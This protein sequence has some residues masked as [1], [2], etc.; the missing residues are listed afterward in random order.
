MFSAIQK[1]ENPEIRKS[2]NPKIH[3]K[4]FVLLF[5]LLASLASAQLKQ[6]K[7]VSAFNDSSN[8][9]FRSQNDRVSV[10]SKNKRLASYLNRLSF[11]VFNRITNEFLSSVPE[12]FEVEI[13]IHRNVDDIASFLKCDPVENK[14]K[15][16]QKD[17]T[18]MSYQLDNKNLFRPELLYDD[19]PYMITLAYLNAADPDGKIPSVLKIGLA[20]SM[21]RSATNIIKNSLNQ[22]ESFWI[23]QDEFFDFKPYE[24]DEVIYLNKVSGT[25]AAWAL[26]LKNN[27]SK[28]TLKNA[29]SEI[30]N[31]KEF[32]VTL[33]EAFELGKYDI[34]PR[35]EEKI[36]NW[37]LNNFYSENKSA[38]QTTIDFKPV[39]TK[40]LPA[41]AVIILVFA[42]LAWIK[43]SIL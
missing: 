36:K 7:N 5:L 17:S 19:I 30:I 21:E 33:G 35:L 14:L 31:G 13:Y 27:C 18:L 3:M 4:H 15:R 11:D 8:T 26:Y 16:W 24:L 29:L 20:H 1:S 43:R 32:S 41:L 28:S 6:I 38:K 42:V 2:K 9:W 12:N 22:N 39:L 23:N 37:I 10:Y 40:A 25:S 34:L